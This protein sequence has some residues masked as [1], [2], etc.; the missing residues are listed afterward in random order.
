MRDQTALDEASS[1]STYVQV[2][3]WLALCALAAKQE[4]VSE[5]FEISAGGC[6]GLDVGSL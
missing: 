1:T 5:L 4:N 6:P 3:L 2:S